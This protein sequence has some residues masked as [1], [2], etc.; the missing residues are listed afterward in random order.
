[1]L[2]TAY[3]IFRRFSPEIIN[4]PKSPLPSSL[5]SSKCGSS[6]HPQPHFNPLILLPPLSTNIILKQTLKTF[7]CRHGKTILE[8][9]VQNC[10]SK[11]K[12]GTRQGPAI[13]PIPFPESFFSTRIGQYRNRLWKGRFQSVLWCFI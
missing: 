4:L 11:V 8:S 10:R 9:E 12:R 1:M 13:S 6:L 7:P 2:L 3:T 5:S